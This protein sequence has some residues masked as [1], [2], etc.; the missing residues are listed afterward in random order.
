MNF[1]TKKIKKI[2]KPKKT[3]GGLFTS[4]GKDGSLIPENLKYELKMKQDDSL[5]DE[6]KIRK[7]NAE[8]NYKLLDAKYRQKDK[9]LNDEDKKQQARNE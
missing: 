7:E 8:S 3:K 9:E 4:L 1:Q 6:Y 2:K 5:I